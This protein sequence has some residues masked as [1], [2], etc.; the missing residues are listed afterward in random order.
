MRLFDAGARGDPG[1]QTVHRRVLTVPNAITAVRL[2]GLPLFVWLMLGPATYGLAFAVLVA[3]GAT[4]WI[5]GYVARRFNQVSRLGKA[6][7]PLI[8][9]VLLAT[10]A[11]T[12]LAVG[13]LPWSIALAIVG[14]DL[15][16]LGAA[17]VM[18]RGIPAIPV[19]RTG[20]LA[21]A[22]LLIGVPGFLLANMDWPGARTFTLIAW[23]FTLVGL[24]AYYVGGVQYGAEAQRLRRRG[25]TEAPDPG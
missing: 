11:L 6:L 24:V 2:A 18:F 19:S 1:A 8:D 25:Q 13:F 17:L 4:D 10:A 3:I 23:A 12:L 5:D 14:R 20:K 16:L 9:R 21:T 7:D 22:C 15:V